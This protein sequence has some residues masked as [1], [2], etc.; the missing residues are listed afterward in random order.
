MWR[1]YSDRRY[2]ERPRIGPGAMTWT[3]IPVAYLEKTKNR[4][5][6]KFIPEPNSGCWLWLATRNAINGY[7]RMGFCGL[8]TYAHRVSWVLYNGEI[9]L[10]TCVLHRCDNP[11]CVNPEHLFLGSTQDN[12]DD[13]INKMRHM[14]KSG[15]DYTHLNAK[16]TPDEVRRVRKETGTANEVAIRLGINVSCVRHIRK[17]ETYKHVL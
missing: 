15:C 4:F 3:C 8:T 6:D 12:I 11:I 16:L 17:K 9:P 1:Y 13:K 2:L 5:Y 7:G 14:V 10:E